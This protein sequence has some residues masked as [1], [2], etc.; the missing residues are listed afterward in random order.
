MAKKIKKA[1][2]TGLAAYAG[3]KM[4]GKGLKGDP[5]LSTDRLL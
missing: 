3:A 5:T 1:I 4:M 2:L